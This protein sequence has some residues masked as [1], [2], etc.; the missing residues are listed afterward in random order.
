MLHLSKQS[1]IHRHGSR[2][3]C[4][5]ATLLEPTRILSIMCFPLDRRCTKKMVRPTSSTHASRIQYIALVPVERNRA[6]KSPE[7]RLSS[8]NG[9][10]MSVVHQNTSVSYYFSTFISLHTSPSASTQPLQRSVSDS[11]QTVCRR[12][13]TEKLCRIP[14]TRSSLQRMIHR[15]PALSSSRNMKVAGLEAPQNSSRGAIYENS[16]AS[17]NLHSI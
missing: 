6:Q 4:S 1:V 11:A 14:L 2:Q 10:G 12:K 3:D 15:T 9:F 16:A 5:R 17:T 13:W 7:R 8:S